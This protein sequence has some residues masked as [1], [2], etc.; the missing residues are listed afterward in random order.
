MGNIFLLFRIHQMDW[1][2]TVFCIGWRSTKDT[3][4]KAYDHATSPEF[5]EDVKDFGKNVAGKT[6]DAAIWAK[7]GIADNVVIPVKD[8]L[9]DEEF[10]QGVKDNVYKAGESVWEGGKWVGHK[11]YELG[12][13]TK[14]AIKEGN[15][16]ETSKDGIVSVYSKTMDAG[17][18]L[19]ENLKENCLGMP[20]QSQKPIL[21]EVDL[22]GTDT[23][24]VTFLCGPDSKWYM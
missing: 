13:G 15:L 10:R 7:D 12:V 2:Q 11:T 24:V 9:A 16:M 19:K 4:K 22:L 14:D 18:S 5:V 21:D 23:G 8:K 20:V 1:V 6:K 17:C 3:A